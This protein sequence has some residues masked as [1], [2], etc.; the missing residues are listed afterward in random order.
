MRGHAGASAAYR[1][2]AAYDGRSR[3][4]NGDPFAG[5]RSANNGQ[6]G[7]SSS[8]SASSSANS[9]APFAS[10][11]AMLS[12]K[13]QQVAEEMEASF[14]TEKDRYENALVTLR[15]K[16]GSLRT[17][18]DL[19]KTR[20]SRQQELIDSLQQQLHDSQLV[21]NMQS[22][23]RLLEQGKLVKEV[24][25]LR[26]EVMA[27]RFQVL[28]NGPDVMN[29]T[30]R[31]ENVN[32]NTPTKRSD[33][34]NAKESYS[35][36]L[37]AAARDGKLETVKSLLNPERAI[38]SSALEAYRRTL[39]AALSEAAS[40][41]GRKSLDMV[42]LLLTCGAD[43]FVAS[44]EKTGWNAVHCASKAG[45]DKSLEKMLSFGAKAMGR[46][47]E[48]TVEPETQTAL[49]LA[50]RGGH[51][52]C[53]R[54]LMRNGADVTA[55]DKTGKTPLELAELTLVAAG[56]ADA[57][58]LARSRASSAGSPKSI[59]GTREGGT[60]DPEDP[61]VSADDAAPGPQTQATDEEATTPR[62]GST[63]S[64][65]SKTRSTRAKSKH[66]SPKATAAAV[67][68]AAEAEKLL[69][70]AD[71]L[72]WSHSVRANRLYAQ[73]DFKG[74]L[75]AYSAAIDLA[76]SVKDER[77]ATQANLATLYY[78]S[79]R[80]C[81]KAGLHLQAIER[82]STAIELRGGSY[83]NALAQR[84]SSHMALFDYA[85]AVTDYEQLIQQSRADA[86]P[87]SGSEDWTACL[88]R[89]RDLAA[90][91]TDHYL[92]LGLQADATPTQVKQSF[93]K[94]CLKWHPDKHR[95]SADDTARA[96][97]MFKAINEANEILS[98]EQKRTLYD[99]DRISKRMDDI[100][101]RQHEEQT[102]WN[103]AAAAAE[104]NA[105]YFSASKRSR[106]AYAD[107]RSPPYGSET[108]R[109]RA[110]TGFRSSGSSRH[111]NEDDDDLDLGEDDDDL[112]EG[113]VDDDDD[114][115]D[116]DVHVGAAHHDDDDDDL[117]D[118]SSL[119]ST[120][121]GF[122]IH[123]DGEG[124]PGVAS[125]GGDGVLSDDD[126]LDD[127][128]DDVDEDEIFERLHTASRNFEARAARSRWSNAGGIRRSHLFSFGFRGGGAGSNSNSSNANASFGAGE[129][130]ARSEFKMPL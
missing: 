51:A 72:F 76:E 27:L 59:A 43:P 46:H 21:E 44:A 31:G 32:P 79:A 16:V 130:T 55:R 102:Q 13:L 64:E 22:K 5:Y 109:A 89:A 104:A 126:D 40:T 37:L 101:R 94:Q 107:T 93:R 25:S 50:A 19:E 33:K 8:S 62:E 47:L 71:L 70:D 82:C 121:D 85:R 106:R 12:H 56:E 1:R 2:G 105:S 111:N 97:I 53:V 9:S 36:Q 65:E 75:A 84:A 23:E 67:V 77:V 92:V 20:S 66:K 58:A 123:L 3:E 41:R 81:V 98:D 42:T 117:D 116:D 34:A 100:V 78:N 68:K 63:P 95:G 110:G 48:K 96:S 115:D 86:E 6:G 28:N 60:H 129:S 114:D 127:D 108:G 122:E 57:A 103:A 15:D 39:S 26:A 91:A 18:L 38:V 118:V 7:A 11:T 24:E 124:R 45:S 14:T 49:H 73:E 128:D 99:I 52:R 120:S 88:E 80:A 10:M 119:G 113:V 54:L 29:G 90:K 83:K 61:A 4:A 74:A 112:G 125:V 17:S 69:R 30:G 35:Q 87:A